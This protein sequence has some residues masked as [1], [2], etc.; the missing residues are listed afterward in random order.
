MK[1]YKDILNLTNARLEG[2]E[3]LASIHVSRGM[4]FRTV[5][6]KLLPQTNSR[7]IE[8]HCVRSGRNTSNATQTVLQPFKPVRANIKAWLL[9]QDAYTL[10]RGVRKRFPMNHYTVNNINDVWK[11]EL[12]DV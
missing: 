9:K 10:H 6:T 2:Y 1:R 11:S 8:A 7:G 3:P 4:K 12:I 5:R